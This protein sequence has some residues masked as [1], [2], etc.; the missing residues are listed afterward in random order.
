MTLTMG[1]H[2]GFLLPH[3]CLKGFAKERWYVSHSCACQRTPVCAAVRRKAIPTRIPTSQIRRILCS[4]FFLR[5]V[6]SIQAVVLPSRRPIPLQTLCT[7]PRPQ[8]LFHGC[9]GREWESRF[10]AVLC[11]PDAARP[12]SSGSPVN[13]VGPCMGLPAAR[14][15]VRSLPGEGAK[16]S[17]A[18][19]WPMS[20]ALAALK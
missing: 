14:S 20:K 11:V 6:G 3:S 4:I 18:W 15:W 12:S 1:L 10:R 5:S 17:P 13:P 8:T 2:R 7:L 19:D 16:R 9:L